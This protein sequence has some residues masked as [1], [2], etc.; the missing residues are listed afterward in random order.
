MTKKI[1]IVASLALASSLVSGCISVDGGGRTVCPTS[2]S[3]LND[4]FSRSWFTA[5][6]GIMLPVRIYCPTSHPS[7]P[8]PLVVYLH[9]AGQNGDDNERQLDDGVGCLHAFTTS[10]EDYN[11]VVAAPQCPSGVYWRDDSMLRA[12]VEMIGSLS[13]VYFIDKEHI[14]VTGFSMGG[15]ATWKLGLR[16]PSL[17]T[18]IVPVCGGPLESMEPDIPE[19]PASMA[20]LNIWAFN[21]FDD[22]VVRPRYSKR[23]FAKLWNADVGDHLNFTESVAGGHSGSRVYASR[24]LLIWMLT[25]PKRLNLKPA[26]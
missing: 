1:T 21:S 13:S 15:D 14:I 17:M 19:V 22:G 26:R 24:D 9:G 10:R 8:L 16:D 20:S 12:L 18:T 23:I 6:T 25:V 5:S 7:R 4:K 11:A 3:E 2:H